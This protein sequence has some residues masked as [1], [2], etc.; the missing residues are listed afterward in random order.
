MADSVDYKKWIQRVEQDK[1]LLETIHETGISG[2]EETFC[3]IC[4]QGAEKILKAYLVRMNKAFQKSHDLVFLLGKCV[5]LNCELNSLEDAVTILN[6]Y[7]VSARYPNDF[8]ETRTLAE[9]KEALELFKQ[10]YNE[11][12]NLM[13]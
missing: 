7:S 4:H 12:I 8:D 11:I 6:E 3:Y 1:K 2:M 13:N 5:E 9:A 10:V